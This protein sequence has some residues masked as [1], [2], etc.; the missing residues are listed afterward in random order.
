MLSVAWHPSGRVL[1]V[2]SADFSVTIVTAF[3]EESL[4]DSGFEGSFNKIKS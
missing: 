1:A 4:E 2:G 3:V